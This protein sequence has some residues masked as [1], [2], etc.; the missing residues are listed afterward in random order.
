MQLMTQLMRDHADISADDEAFLFRLVAEWQLVAD[1]SFSD[2]VLWVPDR[3]PNIFWAVAQI[4]PTTGPTALDDDVAGDRLAY[5]PEQ[6]VPEAYLTGKIVETSEN[7][8]QAGVPVGVH[9]I[10]IKRCDRVVA[11]VE[12]HTNQMGVRAPGSLEDTYLEIAETL[13]GMLERGEFPIPGIPSDP[14]ISPRV[15][16]GLIRLDAHLNVMYATPNA[17]TAYRRMGLAADLEDEN[18]PAITR[19]LQ[20]PVDWESG[21][22]DPLEEAFALGEATEIGVAVGMIAIR[23]RLLPLTDGNQ[24][25]G[26]V[27]LCRDVTELTKRERQLVTKDATIREIHHRVKNNLQTVAALLR[28]QARRIQSPEARAALTEAVSRVAAI[29][30]V[31]ETLSQSYDDAVEFDDVADRVLAMVGGLALTRGDN[32]TAKREGSFGLV[33][34]DVATNLSL[35][36]TE[37]CQN[38]LEHGLSDAHRGLVRVRPRLENNRLTVE[39]IDDGSGLPADF[40]L[41]GSRSLGLSIVGT[42][43]ADLGGTFELAN[44]PEG[45]G[46]RAVISLPLHEQMLPGVGDP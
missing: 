44:N 23:L 27:V 20:V 46:S 3:D 37:L 14:V 29:A 40:T 28:M 42:L 22:P 25:A 12:R 1:L 5:Q 9:A 7:R 18:L 19:S 13:T 17:V 31:H 24:C 4:R 16:D 10:P 38:A 11:V 41:E 26:V 21:G 35:V 15:G 34:A 33:P 36:V 39:V 32:V 43:M 45:P 6:G 8:I 2:L 30:V